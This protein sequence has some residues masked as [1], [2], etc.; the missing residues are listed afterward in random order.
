MKI[1]RIFLTAIVNTNSLLA[2]YSSLIYLNN[3]ELI[4]YLN[5]SPDKIGILDNI[6][7]K[8]FQVFENRLDSHQRLNEQKN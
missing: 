3:K 1:F 2:L 4:D 6:I 5:F 8:K 7:N